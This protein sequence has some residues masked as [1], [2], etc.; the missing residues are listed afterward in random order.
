[1]ANARKWIAILFSSC[2]FKLS[3]QS[4]FIITSHLIFGFFS[5]DYLLVKS[6]KNYSEQLNTENNYNLAIDLAHLWET[7]E[8]KRIDYEMIRDVVST[9]LSFVRHMIRGWQFSGA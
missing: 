5:L 9:S 3:V 2:T 1:M 4:I 7:R 6:D 8:Q